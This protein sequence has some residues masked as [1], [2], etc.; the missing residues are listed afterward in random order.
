[1][2]LCICIGRGLHMLRTTVMLP[3][4]LKNR[5]QASA[6]KKGIS[7]GELIRESLENALL[8]A[9]NAPRTDPFFEDRHFF[10]GDVPTD[11]SANHDEYL[12]DNIH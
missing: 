8:Q 4:S 7:L 6:F 1:M 2:L 10:D 3:S 5:A 9:K 11:L 12:H